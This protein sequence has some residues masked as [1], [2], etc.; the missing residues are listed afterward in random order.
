MNSIEKNICEA[1]DIIVQ[2][3]V[4]E[5]QYDKT[6]QGTIIKCVDIERGKYS[7]RYQDSIFYAYSNNSETTY[8]NGTNVYILIPG[9]D[10]S[11]VKTI[12][13]T[14][15]KLGIDYIPAIDKSDLYEVNGNNCVTSSDIFGL[16]SYRKGSYVKVLYSDS[17]PESQNLIKLDKTAVEQYIKE[18]EVI[19]C[20]ATIRTALNQEQ[21]YRG[22]YGIIFAFDFLDNSTGATVTKY[23]TIDVDKMTGNPYKLIFDTRQ[24]GIFDIDNVNFQKVNYI[25]IFTNNF[26]NSK[27]NDQLADDIFISDIELC[28]AARINDDETN[29]Y[30]LSII[31]PQGTYF[32]ETSVLGET[33]SLQAQ[34]KIKGQ[35]IDNTSDNLSFYWF[36]EDVGI[37]YQSLYY[38]NY[39]GCGWKCLNSYTVI[40][41]AE[42]GEQAV[43]DWASASY[44]LIIKKSDVLAKEARYKCV[45]VYN[46]S[47][48]NK[49][50][51]IKNLSSNYNITIESDSGDQFYFD[52]GF[53]TLTCKIN[54][55]EHLEYTYSW[56][57]INNINDFETLPETS[58]LN[59]E[60]QTAYNNYTNLLNQIEKEE[61]PEV[62][63]KD[64]LEQLEQDLKKYD[65]ITRVNKNKIYNLNINTITVF[66]K[67]S[68]TV[69]NNDIYLGTA[70]IVLKNSLETEGTYSLVINDGSYVYKYNTDGVSPASSALESPIEIKALTF[71]VYNNLGQ[72]IDD[73]IIKRSSIK[74]IIPTED[75]LLKVPSS[76]TPSE[77]DSINNTAT[78]NNLMSFNYL[79]S[80]I[81]NINKKRNNIQL[82]VTYKDMTLVAMTD[83]TFVKEGESGTNGTDFICKIVPNTPSG[84]TPPAYPILTQ[85]S[86]IYWSFN[87]PLVD[88]NVPFRAQLWHNEN[89]IL[90]SAETTN[91]AEGKTAKVTWSILKNKYLINLYDYSSLDID[92]TTG[93]FAYS[94]YNTNS[95]A[96]IIKVTVEY[97][98]V[99]YYAT[100]PLITVKITDSNYRVSLKDDTGFMY[101]MYSADGQDPQYDNVNPFEL[102]VTQNVGSD[103]WEDITK[104]TTSQYAVTYRWNYLG[105]IYDGNGWIDSI[106]LGDRYGAETES[107]QKAAKP[108]D[109]YDGL[110][111]TNAIEA[112]VFKSGSEV[113]RIH[114]PIHLYLNRFGNSAING[115]DGNSVSIDEQGGV[116]LVPQ[117]G[118]GEKDSNNRFTGAVMGKVKEAGKINTEVGLFGYNAGERT[119]KLSAKDGSA[120]FGKNNGGQVLIDPSQNKALLYSHNFWKSYNEEGLPS[121][122]YIGNQN[123]EGM[124]IDLSEPSIKWG[125]SNFSIDSEG[126][127]VA[128]NVDLSGKIQAVEGYIGSEIRGWIIESD[129]IRNGKTSEADVTNKGIYIGT[130][131]IAFGGTGAYSYFNSDGTFSLARGRVVFNDGILQLNNTILQSGNFVDGSGNFSISGT[132]LDLTNGIIK[133]QQFAIDINGNAYYNGKLSANNIYGGNLTLGGRDNINGTLRILNANGEQIGKWDKDGIQSISGSITSISG[134]T[135]V[136]ISGGRFGLAYGSIAV[137]YIGTNSFSAGSSYAGLEFD[138]ESDGSYMC[139]SSKAAA[140]DPNYYARL[141][142]ANKD[143]SNFKKNYL[144]FTSYSNHFLNP[145]IF[146]SFQDPKGRIAYSDDGLMI[147]AESSKHINLAINNSG[148]YYIYFYLS[149]EKIN[150]ARNI[151]MN[152]FTIL[153]QSDERLKTNIQES[154]VAAL[155]IINAIKTYSFDWIENKE[156][157][158]VGFIAQ[159]LEADVNADFINIDK[160]DTHYSVKEMNMIPYLVKA[161]QEL[162][163]QVDELKNEIYKSKGETMNIKAQRKNIIKTWI[164]ETYTIEEKNKFVNRLKAERIAEIK[165]SDPIVIKTQYDS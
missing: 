4:S 50:V 145:A 40:K 66:S 25:S 156:H 94:G 49:I 18:S 155:N 165:Y 48:M 24:Y 124:L 93:L 69:Y 98:G 125:N 91:S 12:L 65:T 110:C 138:L 101:A 120:M 7:V 86:D 14:T 72:K 111:V 59:Q 16:C 97:D 22:N 136:G 99:I 132:R 123:N 106:N 117:I 26:P 5:A 60:Y 45:A 107:Y 28:G 118:A 37:G 137:G 64:K 35:I 147:A 103:Q 55:E 144:Y 79:I 68:C 20:G 109:S 112:I 17:Y 9:N 39:G 2:K 119:F 38:N 32:D 3:A 76:Y 163:V 31:T 46:Q 52:I 105:Q 33:K 121:N 6:I 10:M 8:L 27:P 58:D 149:D 140:S 104:K 73:E 74:W 71:D 70:S 154:N 133:S 53:P 142:Y 159:Q 130:N 151:D 157:V 56:A 67:Y 146:G 161:M 23:Y 80:D 42:A 34:V 108:L 78:Y 139:W 153:N 128:N 84:V 148:S 88:P 61:V 95:P 96:N 141:L 143:F 135:G 131:K 15:K 87:Y 29:S 160:E 92:S 90:D 43:V 122:Y 63:N 162:S 134:E 158:D 75:T 54:G 102:I 100:I 51:T 126:N 89:K 164:P 36:V 1:I 57:V 13:G 62:S 19:I 127:M 44:Q 115:W 11:K 113:A 150:I 30:N 41:P 152:Y 114:I 47:I 82:Q 116:I 81:Y 85:L 77:I 129:N 21:Q 83:L